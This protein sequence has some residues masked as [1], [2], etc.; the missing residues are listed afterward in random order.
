[1]RELDFTILENRCIAKNTYLMRLF[2]DASDCG[3]GQFVN[4]RVEGDFLRR[5]IS[6]C[7]ADGESLTLIYKVVGGGTEKLSR[8]P[9]SASV[10]ILTG[11]GNGYDLSKSGD[12]PLLLGGGVGVPPLYKLAKLLSY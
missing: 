1:M 9:A 10:N 2:G 11:L 3:A 4:L 12:R 6:V 8:L 7:D 5:P